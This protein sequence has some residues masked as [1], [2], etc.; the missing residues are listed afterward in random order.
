MPENIYEIIAKRYIG[1]NEQLKNK[2][3]LDSRGE[4]TIGIGCKMKRDITKQ[5][6]QEMGLSWDKAMRG[7]IALTADQVNT[8]FKM[9]IQMQLM[10][11]VNIFQ[12]LM[13]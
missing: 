11:L 10:M 13:H 3:Y 9:I 12:V 1:V 8:L 4:P 5:K 6:F 7:E 2:V